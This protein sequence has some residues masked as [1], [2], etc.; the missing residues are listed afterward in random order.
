MLLKRSIIFGIIL[1]SVSC[2]SFK[3]KNVSSV[4]EQKE[5]DYSYFIKDS[6]RVY[7]S[8]YLLL[9]YCLP[10][11]SLDQARKI[12][13]DIVNRGYGLLFKQGIITGEMFYQALNKDNKF[14]QPLRNMS[15]YPS[16]DSL[17][18]FYKDIYSYNGPILKI[19]MFIE[20][21][22]DTLK[23]PN[24]TS[25]KVYATPDKLE[26]GWGA[27]PMFKLVI[28]SDKKYKEKNSTTY[29]NNS[30]LLLLEYLGYEL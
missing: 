30:K 17:P 14:V 2:I 8:P 28:E 6:V 9:G 19:L 20:Q 11:D 7:F 25:Y 27:C 10:W 18:S 5:K 1:L 29:F 26:D 23:G 4:I 15:S 12:N 13:S 16:N 21:E 22:N 24:I 3:Q